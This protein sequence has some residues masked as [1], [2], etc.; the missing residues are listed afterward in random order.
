[1]LAPKKPTFK[2]L[3]DDLTFEVGSFIYCVIKVSANKRYISRR[4]DCA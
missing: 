3:D 1:M 2:K 4:F